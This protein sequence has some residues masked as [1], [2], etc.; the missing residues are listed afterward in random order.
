MIK[1]F[2]IWIA[3]LI[4]KYVYFPIAK[5]FFGFYYSKIESDSESDEEIRKIMTKIK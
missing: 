3:S 2:F 4:V 5:F 1:G